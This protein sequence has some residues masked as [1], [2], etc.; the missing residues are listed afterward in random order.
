M[1]EIVARTVPALLDS[2]GLWFVRDLSGSGEGERGSVKPLAA[3][4]YNSAVTMGDGGESNRDED[5]VAELDADR[6]AEWFEVC[7]LAD[8]FTELCEDITW[9]PPQEQADGAVTMGYAS[10]SDRVDH[11]VELLYKIGAVTGRYNW[12]EHGIPGFEGSRSLGAADAVRA[13]TG[14]VRSDRFIEGNLGGF[15]ENGQFGA[16]LSALAAWYRATSVNT[17]SRLGGAKTTRVWPGTL[18]RGDLPPKRLVRL[19]AV[20][21][22]A[23][24]GNWSDLLGLLDADRSVD[25]NQCRV[26]GAS[27]FAPLHQAAW[28]GAP[29]DVAAALVAR[30][31]WRTLREAKGLRPVDIARKRGHEH[32]A[33]LLAPREPDY[34]E[35]GRFEAWDRHLAALIESTI[36][37]TLTTR[38]RDVATEVLSEDGTDALY[39]AVPGMYGGFSLEIFK[40][41]LHVEVRSRVV[42][43]GW[44]RAYVLN[45]KGV[46]LVDEGF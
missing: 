19:D 14:F 10:Y 9:V 40:G 30:G 3:A 28:H 18:D 6:T 20:A 43:D 15:V 41:R 12:P 17:D 5:L 45:E 27:W 23:R 1:R 31:A 33:D 4:R 39:L 44:A 13:A 26:G 16:V 24:D 37:P 34:S 8:D 36:R 46:T 38:L 11:A 32:L 21:D 22:A 2:L 42:G 25:V 7:V 29:V 35:A